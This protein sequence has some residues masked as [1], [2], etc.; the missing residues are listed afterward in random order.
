MQKLS[1]AQVIVEALK[2]EET[3]KG[4]VKPEDDWKDIK[5]YKSPGCDQCNKEGYHGRIGIY[6]VLEVDEDIQ[7]LIAEKATSEEIEESARKKGMFTM[8]EDG[9]IKAVQGITSIEEI[10]RVT[11]E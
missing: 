3:L 1:G 2:K 9:F 7:K 8:A 6:E 4:I 10:L 11:K 5:F